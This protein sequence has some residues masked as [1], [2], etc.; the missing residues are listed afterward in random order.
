MEVFGTPD[1]PDLLR[2]GKLTTLGGSEHLLIEFP[3]DGYGRAFDVCS[4][5]LKTLEQALDLGV[6]II[7]TSGQ[8]AT[9]W[10]GRSLIGTLLASAGNKA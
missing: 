4:N 7:L 2:A 10:E 3:F 6:D 5:P 8:Q 9:A 1:T